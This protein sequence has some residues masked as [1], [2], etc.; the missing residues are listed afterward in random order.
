M[1]VAA[2][3]VLVFGTSEVTMNFLNSA[4]IR[5]GSIIRAQRHAAL[6]HGG[7]ARRGRADYAE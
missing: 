3:K 6:L 7:H 4:T 2:D 5:L 1:K